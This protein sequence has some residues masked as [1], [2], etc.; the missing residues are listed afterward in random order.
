MDF[1]ALKAANISQVHML[2][3]KKKKKNPEQVEDGVT[4]FFFLVVGLVD[5][6]AWETKQH[7]NLPA[8]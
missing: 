1:P 2:A 3:M 6:L 5:F 7:M 8:S 4:F